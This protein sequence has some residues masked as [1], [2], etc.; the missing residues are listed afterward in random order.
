M[1]GIDRKGR[2]KLL[3]RPMV[4]IRCIRGIS[5]GGRTN[6]IIASVAQFAQEVG[7]W[8]ASLIGNI[9]N[10]ERSVSLASGIQSLSG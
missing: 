3:E 2:H 4:Q 1:L 10:H 7:K 6:G 5:G 9:D 8:R